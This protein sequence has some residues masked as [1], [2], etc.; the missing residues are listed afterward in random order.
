MKSK[1]SAL[2]IFIAPVLFFTCLC[3]N[4]YVNAQCSVDAGS[5]VSVVVGYPPLACVNLTATPTGT[6]PFSFLWSTGDTTQT[7]NVCPTANTDYWVTITDSSLCSSSDTVT[8]TVVDVRCGNDSTKVLVCHAPPG[9]P[10]NAH[11]ICISPNAV[12][13][14]LAHGDV[15]GSCAPP[16]PP[17]CSVDL[18]NDGSFCSADNIQLDAGPGFVSYLW[19]DSSTAQTL[20]VTASGAYWVQVTDSNNCV[21]TDTINIIVNPSPSASAGNDTTV[22]EPG[23]A[24]L[25]GSATGGT[26]PYSYLW[27]TGDTTQNITFCNSAGVYTLSFMV[28]DSN[29]CTSVDTVVVTVTTPCSVNLGNDTA[30]CSGEENLVL[31]AGAGFVSYLWSDSS[32]AQTFTVLVSGIY[33]VQ[34]TDSTNCTATDSINVTLFPSPAANAGN[35]TSVVEPDCAS[36]FGTVIGGTPPYTYLWSTGD[37]TQNI[38]FCNG[39]GTYT[40][41]FMVTD[42]NGCSSVDSVIVTVM[43]QIIINTDPNPNNGRM[44]KV[45]FVLPNPGV[46]TLELYDMTGAKIAVLFKEYT[47]ENVNYRVDFSAENLPVGIYTVRLINETG[48]IANTKMV[49]VR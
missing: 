1:N 33:W 13:A 9:N 44:A 48:I 12:P 37:T 29:G 40:L 24:S 49:L 45:T 5:D 20:T 14:H 21:A 3:S 4:T 15:L 30:L 34:A 36:L 8:V 6:P 2:K 35:D 43:P 17:P 23:C 41:L 38:T 26:P 39:T 25:F 16:P 28:T 47:K 7:I 27:S 22:V 46:T 19:S 10:A 31:D 42:S 32:T 11:T 18:G